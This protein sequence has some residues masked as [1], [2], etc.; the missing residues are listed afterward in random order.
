MR[1]QDLEEALNGWDLVAD[2]QNDL[3]DDAALVVARRVAALWQTCPGCLGQGRVN[4]LNE[5]TVD[6]E[7]CSRCWGS[8]GPVPSDAYL[9]LCHEDD[10][11]VPVFYD[12]ALFRYLFGEG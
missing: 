9:A 11:G 5:G 8:G 4:V 3:D 2:S 6:L 12:Y 1:L 10:W 7:P